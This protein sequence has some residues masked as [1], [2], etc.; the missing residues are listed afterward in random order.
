MTKYLNPDWPCGSVGTGSSKPASPN[1]EW[2]SERLVCELVQLAAARM[3][4]LSRETQDEWGY[5]LE[6]IFCDDEENLTLEWDSYGDPNPKRS[7]AGWDGIVL[8]SWTRDV[9][10]MRNEL[11]HEL[12]TMALWPGAVNLLRAGAKL[13]GNTGDSL[14]L[15]EL[16]LTNT[17]EVIRE[18]LTTSVM[19]DGREDLLELAEGILPEFDILDAEDLD[20]NELCDSI[21]SAIVDLQSVMQN[22]DPDQL[23]E[24]LG[25]Y[26]D[27][28]R[29]TEAWGSENAETVLA[30]L[31]QLAPETT[32]KLL[33]ESPPWARE[34]A[35]LLKR[36]EFPCIGDCQGST[37]ALHLE[38]VGNEIGSMELLDNPDEPRLLAA[39]ESYDVEDYAT[40]E[41]ALAPLA[42]EGNVTAIFKYAN[43]LDFLGRTSEAEPW[44]QIAVGFGHN[45]AMNNLGISLSN[46]G[47]FDEAARLYENSFAAGNPEGGFNLAGLLKDRGDIDGFIALLE[48]IGD[49]GMPRAY[50]RLGLYYVVDV[51]GPESIEKAIVLFNKGISARNAACHA[52]MAFVAHS[53]EDVGDVCEWAQRAFDCSFDSHEIDTGLPGQLHGLLGSAYLKFEDYESALLHLEEANRL[54]AFDD[55]AYSSVR[56]FTEAQAALHNEFGPN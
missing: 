23:A 4:I 37:K 3:G 56:D 16:L 33:S 1:D 6:I 39:L 46:R 50:A 41:H 52:G 42:A 24:V 40:A 2:N 27:A 43:T 22:G 31:R 53:K 19:E 21:T 11:G 47:E 44:W 51:G 13:R 48:R 36:G 20:D 54:G 35:D 30:S 55:A 32:S 14:D 49:S 34:L 15:D 9:D 26:T 25:V 10:W 7:F 28:S 18:V 17:A 45:G 12:N 5:E 29:I 8:R 38:K